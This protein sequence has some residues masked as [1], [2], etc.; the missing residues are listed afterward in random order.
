MKNIVVAGAGFGG[1]RCALDLAFYLKNFSDYKIVVFDQNLYHLYTPSL[2]EVATAEIQKRCVCLP[3]QHLFDGKQISFIHAKIDKID[4]QEK[5]VKLVNGDRIPYEF[6]VL[7]LGGTTDY[8]GISGL[9]KCSFGLKSLRE[10]V[11]LRNHL[12]EVFQKAK[13]DS[14]EQLKE[15]LRI[16]VGGGG[17]SGVELAGELIVYVNRLSQ[18]YRLDPRKVALVLV[19][20]SLNLLPGL[21]EK[22]SNLAKIRL[23]KLGVKILTQAGIAEVK[24]DLL[25][26]A[27]GHVLPTA[28]IIWA[29]GIRAAQVIEESGMMVDKK[30][31]LTVDENL[32]SLER[33]EIFAL[34][35]NACFID[36]KTGNPVPGQAEAAID[37]GNLIAKNIIASISGRPLKKY[38]PK[39]SGFIIP[40]GGNYAIASVFGIIFTGYLAMALKKLIELRYLLSILPPLKALR[41]FSHEAQL[42][43]E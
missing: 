11:G 24:N 35:D 20:A 28:T 29:G 12:R 9:E 15:D 38:Y 25:I 19:E 43:L 22:I 39:I 18:E 41:V 36:Q 42:L 8:F 13:T 1:V 37:Q 23:E 40:I 7:A 14:S 2:Y 5:I 26:L 6:L 33:K 3:Y 17:F 10:A 27:N 21:S 32:R 30:G 34:G 31:R 4:A 16:V